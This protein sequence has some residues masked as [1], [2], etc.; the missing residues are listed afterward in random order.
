MQTKAGEIQ[1]G[2]L[3]NS[4]RCRTIIDETIILYALIKHLLYKALKLLYKSSLMHIESAT[5]FPPVLVHSVLHSS[6]FISCSKA[7]LPLQVCRRDIHPPS[8]QVS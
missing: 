1:P 3:A 2:S 8:W 6:Y 4:P 5:L 7:I